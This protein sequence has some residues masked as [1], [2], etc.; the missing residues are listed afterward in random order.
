LTGVRWEIYGDPAPETGH[1]DV[2]L[3]WQLT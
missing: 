1:F 3:Y 2:T